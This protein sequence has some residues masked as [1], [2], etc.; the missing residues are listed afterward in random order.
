MTAT[1]GVDLEPQSKSLDL[2]GR[3]FGA[4]NGGN[5]S[6]KTFLQ[7]AETIRALRKEVDP[8]FHQKA[9]DFVAVPSGRSSSS[10]NER[11]VGG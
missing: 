6:R 10:P 4:V 5:D 8:D 2:F 7:S 9:F 1:S 11:A 3:R